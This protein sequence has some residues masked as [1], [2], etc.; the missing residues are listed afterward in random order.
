MDDLEQMAREWLEESFDVWIGADLDSL[1][2]LLQRVRDK[3]KVEAAEHALLK[4]VEA[5]AAAEQRGRDEK[6]FEIREWLPG[7][8]LEVADV[9]RKQRDKEW[10]Q[11]VRDTCPSC[12]RRWR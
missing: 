6:E 8:D 1:A 4:G 10:E 11:A 12:W 3:T 7:H 2:A 9:A 5:L